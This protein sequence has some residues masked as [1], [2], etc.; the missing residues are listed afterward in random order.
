MKS[1]GIEFMKTLTFSYQSLPLTRALKSVNRNLP[2]HLVGLAL[3]RG[4]SWTAVGR[5]MR[6]FISTFIATSFVF[7]G[8]SQAETLLTEEEKKQLTGVYSYTGP[9]DGLQIQVILE[10]FQDDAKKLTG[11]G[12]YR[13]DNWPERE[14]AA[15]EFHSFRRLSA[16][17]WEQGWAVTEMAGQRCDSDRVCIVAVNEY[18]PN[19][20]RKSSFRLMQLTPDFSSFQSYTVAKKGDPG[21]LGVV[22]K[23]STGEQK[24]Q[25]EDSMADGSSNA[26]FQHS[27]QAVQLQ[28]ELAFWKSVE[29][30]ED[31]SMLQAYLK[32]YPDG[33]FSQIAKLR[34][35]QLKKN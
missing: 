21:L 24:G 16:S 18:G 3:S 17:E 7:T 14:W 27:L 9:F 13:A 31:L 10:F 34:I 32:K 28:M 25:T 22:L 33:V 8:V 2:V 26:A 11:E 15:Q 35:E 6:A 23:K 20:A 29:R 5:I 30:H 19:D 12:K 4:K 1:N